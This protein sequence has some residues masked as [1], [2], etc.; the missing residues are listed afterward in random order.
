MTP[1]LN[2]VLKDIDHLFR[3][4]R[5]MNSHDILNDFDLKAT[6]TTD[7]ISK[8]DWLFKLV[9]VVGVTLK[10]LFLASLDSIGEQGTGVLQT[11]NMSDDLDDTK[12]YVEFKAALQQVFPIPPSKSTFFEKASHK[13]DKKSPYRKDEGYSSKQDRSNN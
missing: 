10:N 2:E 11:M 3:I 4:N 6:S 1:S 12:R 7:T 5:L 9:T 8:I 13:R